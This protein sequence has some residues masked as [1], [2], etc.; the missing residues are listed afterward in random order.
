VRAGALRAPVEDRFLIGLG[1]SDDCRDGLRERPRRGK[2]HFQ[3]ERF[4]RSAGSAGGRAR[5]APR[6]AGELREPRCERERHSLGRAVGD[7]DAE[8]GGGSS[9]ADRRALDVRVEDR[10]EASLRLRQ[11]TTNSE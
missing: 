8:P 3:N 6:G 10:V 5:G 7:V 4:G 11:R 1:D 2:N 9:C